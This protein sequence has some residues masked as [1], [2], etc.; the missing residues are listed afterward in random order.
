MEQ[1]I[2]LFSGWRW[3]DVLDIVFNAY[4]LFRLY[5]LFRGTN[6]LR[7]LMAVVAMWVIGRSANAMGLII[8]NWILQGVITLATFIIIIVFRNE[9]SGVVRTRSLKFFLWEV[10]RAQIDTPVRIITD[11][12]VELAR[13]KN[14]GIDRDAA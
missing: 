13:S 5:V 1:L 4:I 9:I 11:A 2:L 7:V 10:P 3:Q 14:R 8:T 12:V 6:V